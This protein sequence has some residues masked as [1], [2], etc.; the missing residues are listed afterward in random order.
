MAE[1]AGFQPDD[2]AAYLEGR[3]RFDRRILE[4]GREVVGRV[5]GVV[6]LRRDG[7]ALVYREDGIIDWQDFSGKCHRVYFYRPRAATLV[8]VYFEDGRLF[9]RLDLSQGPS[10]GGGFAVSHSCP[11]D[12]YRGAYRFLAA[13]PTSTA[14]PIVSRPRHAGRCAGRSRVRARTMRSRRTMSATRRRRKSPRR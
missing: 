1:S 8:E 13:R 14:A 6:R 9:H 5:S 10:E 11:P 3:W 4:V 7:A 12:V 2:L